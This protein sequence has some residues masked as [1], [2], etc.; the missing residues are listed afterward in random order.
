MPDTLSSPNEPAGQLRV[1]VV[2]DN[3]DAAETLKV[4]LEINGCTAFAAFDGEAGLHAI[5]KFKP[6]LVIAD[7]NMHKLDGRE[8][9]A[10]ARKLPEGRTATFVCLSAASKLQEEASCL[11]AG[12]DTYV[13]K[14]ISLEMLYGKRPANPP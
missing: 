5:S 14:P 13:Q 3:V 7:L 9:V 6:H 11:E 10:L 4:L 8:L 1:V 2:D 12:F